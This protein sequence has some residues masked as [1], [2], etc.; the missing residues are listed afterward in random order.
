[1]L[2]KVNLNL[3]LKEAISEFL[4]AKNVIWQEARKNSLN[5]MGMT[6]LQ[7]FK[8]AQWAIR[9][10]TAEENRKIKGSLYRSLKRVTDYQASD[11]IGRLICSRNVE[12][13]TPLY[14]AVKKSFRTVADLIV[15]LPTTTIFLERY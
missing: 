3:D 2:N 11:T 12:A 7:K 8:S 6:I 4:L 5:K 1:L 14:L 10:A 9:V 13:K 15:K